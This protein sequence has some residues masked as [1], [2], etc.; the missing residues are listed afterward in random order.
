MTAHECTNT[1]IVSSGQ[2]TSLVKTLLKGKK[3]D[4]K[5]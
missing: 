2:K 1:F 3:H 4:K 5:A